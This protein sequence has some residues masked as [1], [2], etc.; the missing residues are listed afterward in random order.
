[1]PQAPAQNVVTLPQT[2]EARS[3][4]PA[5]AAPSRSAAKRTVDDA[6]RKRATASSV[7]Q[8][9]D[10]CRGRSNFSLLYFMQTQCRKPQFQSS[11]QCMELRRTGDVG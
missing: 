3:P 11:Q 7:P 9:R 4:A 5:Q 2:G 8:P 1:M 10:L 6:A